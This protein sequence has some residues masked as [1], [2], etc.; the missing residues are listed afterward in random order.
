MN[1]GHDRSWIQAMAY[2]HARVHIALQLTEVGAFGGGARVGEGVGT[3]VGA[4]K[5]NHRHVSTD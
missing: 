3:G 5:P 4:L 2:I 1:E